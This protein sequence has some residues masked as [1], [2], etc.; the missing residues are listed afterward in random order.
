MSKLIDDETLENLE[1]MKTEALKRMKNLSLDQ[2]VIDEFQ[3]NN[4][5]YC[6]EKGKIVEVPSDIKDRALKWQQESKCLVYHIIH[7]F[8]FGFETYE[9]LCVSCYKEDWIFENDIMENGWT[10]VKSENKTFPDFSEMG[11][12]K[13]HNIN[14]SLIRIN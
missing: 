2:C 7:A 9:F 13:V 14:G 3:N 6:S 10:M 8:I 4:K 12:I 5:L 11:S 1:S